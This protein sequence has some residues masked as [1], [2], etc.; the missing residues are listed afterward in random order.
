MA[1]LNNQNYGLQREL[2]EFVE[3]DEAVK[4]NLDRK[5]HV[6][7]V[8]KSVDDVIMRS[9]MEVAA[10]QRTYSRGIP[11]RTVVTETVEHGPG[12]RYLTKSASHYSPLRPEPVHSRVAWR[13]PEPPRVE[14]VTTYTRNEGLGK[15]TSSYPERQGSFDAAARTK[16][17][18]KNTSLASRDKAE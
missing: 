5:W 6:D 3:C 10:R 16:V 15:R 4:R 11:E 7:N 12:R 1:T 13:G 9:N 8:R 18:E 14:R 17:T 2:T